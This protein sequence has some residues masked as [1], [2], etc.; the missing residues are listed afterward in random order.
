MGE[1]GAAELARLVES[2]LTGPAS[3]AAQRLA[4]E[5]RSRHGTAVAAV[6]FYGSCLRRD[7]DEG[8][9]DFYVLVDGYR[10]A[11]RSRLLAAANALLPPNVF[12]L[13]L[14]AGDTGRGLRSKYAVLSFADLARAVGPGSLRPGTWARFCQPARAV[15][16]RDAGAR[17]AL[18]GACVR[19]VQTAVAR[20]APLL[21]ACEGIQ[22]FSVEELWQRVFRETYAAEMRTETPETIASLYAADP[23]RYERAARCAL[24]EP[25]ARAWR[26]EIGR[27]GLVALQ[28]DPG[29]RRRARR[30]WR[31]RRPLAKL[32]YAAALFK[33]AATFGDW[34]PYVLW[35]LERH[36]G[37]RLVPSERQR[38]HPLVWGWPLLFRALRRRALR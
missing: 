18:V 21:P 34:L 14:P 36:T 33:S 29:A 9:L 27:D 25:E 7:R 31:R 24:A 17:E 6:I 3:P 37:T 19:S 22:R 10:A 32:A 20:V 26:H 16:L 13:E 11:Y 4:A 2:E 35:K 23:G 8:V 28:M 30:A 38:R 5:I 1:E 15:Y 12:Y